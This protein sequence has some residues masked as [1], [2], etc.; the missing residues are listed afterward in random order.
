MVNRKLVY[1]IIGIVIVV[2]V[3][4]L[5]WN[6]LSGSEELE[7]S[8][9]YTGLK[10]CDSVEENIGIE[11]LSPSSGEIFAVGDSV[12]V[13]LRLTN[14]V[15]EDEADF[16]VGVAIYEFLE[17]ES[18][19]MISSDVKGVTIDNVK[20]VYFDL[21]IPQNVESNRF[22]FYVTVLDPNSDD[23]CNVDFVEI[24]VGG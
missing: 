17:D 9:S 18:Y 15:Y 8:P 7:L 22:E 13:H 2:A 12:G 10:L 20:D 6:Y 19:N 24:G 14:G 16:K 3:G 4:F 11:I 1:L 23:V 5:I 21:L